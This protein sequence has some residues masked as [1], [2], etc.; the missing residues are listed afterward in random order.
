MDFESEFLW[1]AFALL[2]LVSD[3]HLIDPDSKP[4]NRC[5]YVADDITFDVIE[6]IATFEARSRGDLIADA[7]HLLVK[8]RAAEGNSRAAWCLEKY[9]K[10]ARSKDGQSAAD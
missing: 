6:M 3:K 8:T 7:I 5:I 1:H 2:R 10:C 9:Y 4:G